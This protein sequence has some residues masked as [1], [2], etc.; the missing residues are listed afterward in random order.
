M[1]PIDGSDVPA[2]QILME[3]HCAEPSAP[4]HRAMPKTGSQVMTSTVI[5]RPTGVTS[6]L[7][8]LLFPDDAYAAEVGSETKPLHAPRGSRRPPEGHYGSLVLHGPFP[9]NRPHSRTLPAHR[10]IRPAPVR[11]ALRDPA[12]RRGALVGKVRDG[13][14]CLGEIGQAMRSAFGERVDERL[15]RFVGRMLRGEDARPG[16]A[17]GAARQA[18]FGERRSLMKVDRLPSSAPVRSRNSATS[19][20]TTSMR[21]FVSSI[22]L[23]MC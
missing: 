23:S 6:F 9:D 2:G 22:R 1:A 21:R 17:V 12:R 19:R 4:S 15:G 11:P 13:R 8:R 7:Y 16:R 14:T 5:S 18:A 10:R 3:A 20:A